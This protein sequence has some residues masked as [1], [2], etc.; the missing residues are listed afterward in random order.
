MTDTPHSEP[1]RREA[2]SSGD[3]PAEGGERRPA[4]ASG[5]HHD[6]EPASGAEAP[7]EHGR[8]EM[9]GAA[10]YPQFEGP[11]AAQY[12]TEP[13][14]P[15]PAMSSQQTGAAAPI[16][17]PQTVPHDTPG[18]SQAT[19]DAPSDTGYE[20]PPG[21]APGQGGSTYGAP[22]GNAPGQGGTA[23]GTPSGN[24]PGQG[25]TAYGTPPGNAPGQGGPG[26]AAPGAA[27]G[28]G[29]PS[30]G[31]PGAAS[32]QG[33]PGG[34]GPPTQP[35]PGYGEPSYGPP[36]QASGWA[37]P[38]DTPPRYAEAPPGYGQPQH[39]P[40]APPPAGLNVGD[41]LGYGWHKFRDN[42]IP[43]IAITLVGFVAY[44]AVTLVINVGDVN[45]LLPILLIFLVVALVVW[46]L[47]AAMIR[48]GLYECDGTPP[49]FQA[50]FGFV[51]AGNV[52][53]T[54]LL[55]FVAACI[56]MVLFVIPA[57]IVGFLCMF[58]LHFVI[59]RDLD[60]FS[61]IK[62]SAELVIANVGPVLLL[63]LAVVVLTFVSLLLCGIPLL[64]TGPLTAIAM[65]YSYRILV[66]GLI[67]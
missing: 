11:G 20:S 41:A 44:L 37:P 45:S 26:Y 47:Q 7:R 36:G 25:S 29:G 4:A 33:G 38:G 34:Y 60:P 65:T 15:P 14:A 58:S 13:V 62:A 67:A 3:T 51:N 53:L 10:G 6:P 22:P 9:P 35:M 30:Y 40:P 61:A 28:R 54:A 18:G 52:L 16:P 49:D 1:T 21:N 50:F 5:Q 17:S 64:V 56:G 39:A 8:H 55:V 24:A 2:A 63:A 59:D 31:P 57:F 46:L 43:W 42:P 23:Y 27:P 66:D 32:G 12:G 19:S 48:G